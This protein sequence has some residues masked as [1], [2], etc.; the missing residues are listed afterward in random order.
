VA[1]VNRLAEIDPGCRLEKGATVDAFA[2]IGKASIGPDCVI[3]PHTVIDSGAKAGARLK[4]GPGAHLREK[5]ILG[6]DCVVGDNCLVLPG[7]RL[8]DRVVLHSLVLVAEYCRI[9]DGTWIGPGVIILNTLHP[10]AKFCKD[11][12]LG[13]LKGSPVI[14]KDVRIGG[15]AVINPYV[16]IGDRAVIASGSVVTKDVPADTVVAGNPAKVM[17]K[18]R[19]VICREHPGERVYVQE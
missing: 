2:V 11:K 19:D 6:D 4:T 9:G 5:T 16:K 12:A 1:G 15:N 10:K 17:K 13:D 18:V 8:G 14:G 7:A 3:R